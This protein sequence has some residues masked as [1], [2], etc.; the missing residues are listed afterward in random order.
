M[1]MMEYPFKMLIN[2]SPFIYSY[3]K[4]SAKHFLNI[5][6]RLKNGG[7]NGRLGGQVYVFGQRI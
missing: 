5:N 2:P 3:S 7:S 4:R 1:G 6:K